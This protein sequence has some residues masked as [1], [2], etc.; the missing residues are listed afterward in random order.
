MRNMNT[1]IVIDIDDTIC[2]TIE[3]DYINSKPHY[4]II[5]KINMLYDNGFTIILFTARGFISKGRDPITINKEVKP[6]IESWL[7]D[8]NVKYTELIM[9]KPYGAI[10][11]DDK[12]VRPD[13]F[14][15]MRF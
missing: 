15:Q 3:R 6:I 4:D 11:V 10:Y 2:T 1:T 7:S 13:E 12:S 9:H 5:N 14:L 8:N